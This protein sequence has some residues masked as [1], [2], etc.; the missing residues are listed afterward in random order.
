M[1]I[2]WSSFWFLHHAVVYNSNTTQSFHLQLCFSALNWSVV[3][4]FPNW[5]VYS[6]FND[7]IQF[8][9]CVR[10]WSWYYLSQITDQNF[11]SRNATKA[12]SRYT[13]YRMRGSNERNLLG[14]SPIQYFNY[15]ITVIQTV[16]QLHYHLPSK[17]LYRVSSSKQYL[18]YIIIILA[19][20]YIKYHHPS[21]M[22][23]TVSSKH[24]FNY[25]T[26]IIQAVSQL[27]YHHQSSTQLQWRHHPSSL[28]I[29]VT[30]H[31]H[32]DDGDDNNTN[33]NVKNPTYPIQHK[34]LYVA[35]RGWTSQENWKKKNIYIF[36]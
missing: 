13:L 29:I 15:S 36:F 4:S 22:L 5:W 1:L 21:S 3:N 31:K 35:L 6:G 28:S 19:R 17:I 33:N 18:N 27:H 14:T 26:I 20:S 10:L 11:N 25:S 34:T 16:S 24:N 12:L 7:E 23:T 9:R 30:S 2:Q 8:S 32:N